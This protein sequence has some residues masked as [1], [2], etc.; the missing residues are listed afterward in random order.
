MKLLK[1]S[2]RSTNHVSF[3]TVFQGQNLVISG[4]F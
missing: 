2:V 4:D 1:M 3:K